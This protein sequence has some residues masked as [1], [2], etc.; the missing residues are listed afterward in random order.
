MLP[1]AWIMEASM[2]AA[3]NSRYIKPQAVSASIAY[4]EPAKAVP[5]VLVLDIKG[6]VV[7]RA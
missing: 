1:D 5:C 6:V 7:V 3:A 4:N 2:L